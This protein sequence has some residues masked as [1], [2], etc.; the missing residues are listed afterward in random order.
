MAENCPP[1]GDS[2]PVVEIEEVTIQAIDLPG[3]DNEKGVLIQLDLSARHII[4]NLDEPSW[5][6]DDIMKK[7]LNLRVIQVRNAEADRFITGVKEDLVRRGLL[8][9]SFNPAEIGEML[10]VGDSVYTQGLIQYAGYS[11]EHRDSSNRGKNTPQGIAAREQANN[12]TAMMVR[13]NVANIADQ[14]YFLSPGTPGER[15]NFR[16]PRFN[17]DPPFVDIAHPGGINGNTDAVGA[18]YLT[19]MVEHVFGAPVFDRP[20]YKQ[21]GTS[22][23]PI[24][25]GET[26]VSSQ[27]LVTI[28]DK[29]LMND[30]NEFLLEAQETVVEGDQTIVTARIPSIIFG[31]PDNTVEREGDPVPYGDKTLKDSDISYLSYH[32]FFY[33]DINRMLAD[34]ELDDE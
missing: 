33:V 13:M 27:G 26:E 3:E 29:P 2:L 8:G 9:R 16:T 5:L 30:E 22:N 32:A 28:Y 34:M 23:I 1:P 21:L 7:Y 15:F 11:Y 17:D 25:T 6:D 14:L 4:E 18:M 10:Q 24:M 20:S 19:T 31:H 12:L